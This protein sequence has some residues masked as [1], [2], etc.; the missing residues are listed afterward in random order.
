[1]AQRALQRIDLPVTS[2]DLERQTLI[3]SRIDET[4]TFG[5]FE[6]L[7]LDDLG[8]DPKL[9]SVLFIDEAQE[10]HKLGGYVRFMKEAWPA[11]R[12]V[13]SGSTLARIFRDDVRYPVGRVRRLVVRPFTFSEYLEAVGQHQLASL[14]L[15][16]PSALSPR[17]HERL[18][19]HLD[20]HLLVGGLPE[21]ALAHASG[22]DYVRRRAEII[23]D[24]E[25]DFIRLFGED[26]VA[27]VKGCLRSVANFVGS[28][29]KNASVIPQPT[30][31]INDEIRRVFARLES[32]RL[33]L[34]S[35][36]RGPSPEASHRF[37]PK[38]Y[39]FDTGVLRHL[40]E[41]GVPSISILSTLNAAERRPLGGI[42]ENQA[43]I[44]LADRFGELTG[45]KKSSAG[46][47]IDFICR[48]GDQ[49]IPIECKA[50]LQLKRTHLRGL[51]AYLQQHGQAFG[52][53]ISCAPF[54]VVDGPKGT[55]IMNVPLYLAER[56]PELAQ[57]R[58]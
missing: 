41:K 19:T 13:L 12:V 40:R 22:D 25:Q 28:P 54:D 38:R 2:L 11:A 55:R 29:S 34:Q 10:S 53:M 47:E 9:D 51:G 26:T 4:D 6:E 20:Q 36:Q 52:V 58:R 8:F 35:E 1:M 5:D 33:V 42:V 50:V 32:W 14:L 15:S 43:A 7:L 31:K 17:R 39:M 18:L 21:V 27:I 49:S 37:L 45:W 44:E 30:S 16:D 56:L 23:A 24:Y 46:I 57:E 48:I 3:R